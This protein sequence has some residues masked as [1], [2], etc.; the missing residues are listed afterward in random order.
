MARKRTEVKI[1]A[2]VQVMAEMGFDQ[3]LIAK[4]TGVPL[5]T[6]NDI[7][8]RRGH[9]SS[10]SEYNELRETYRLCLRAHILQES[11]ALAAMVLERLQVIAKMPTY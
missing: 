2:L 4:V 1:A 11:T 5:R 9:W 8:N 7:A 10:I 6:I 3:D